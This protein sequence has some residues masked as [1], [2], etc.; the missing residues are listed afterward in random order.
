MK[1]YALVILLVAGCGAKRDQDTTVKPL[2]VSQFAAKRDEIAAR[3]AEEFLDE[4]YVVSRQGDESLHIGDAAKYTG[5]G[6]SVMECDKT[7]TMFSAIQES[8]VANGG[9]IVRYHSPT[10][11]SRGETS[12]DTVTGV[13]MGLLFHQAR[14]GSDARSVWQSHYDFVTANDGLLEPPVGDRLSPAMRWYWSEIGYA[15]GIGERRPIEDKGLWETSLL[16]NA[17]FAQRLK[18]PCYPIDLGMLQIIAMRKLGHN[19]DPA[20]RAQLCAATKEMKLA[21]MDHYCKRGDTLQWL[22][23]WRAD[24]YEYSLQICPWQNGFLSEGQRSH[25]VDFLLMYHLAKGDLL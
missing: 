10:G 18:Q 12:Y 14:C 20:V 24:E 21:H 13:S 22:R 19:L 3:L 4:G 8:T 7:A 25:G 16:I 23:D 6:M 1:I 9:K 5:I 2:D 11:S 17:E 15:L